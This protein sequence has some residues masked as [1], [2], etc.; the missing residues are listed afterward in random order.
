MHCTEHRAVQCPTSNITGNVTFATGNAPSGVVIGTVANFT[1]LPSYVWYGEVSGSTVRSGTCSAVNGNG[2][3]VLPKK[4]IRALSHWCLY[5][6]V[7]YTFTNT[8]LVDKK[9]LR[10]KLIFGQHPKGFDLWF[11]FMLYMDHS[12]VKHDHRRTVDQ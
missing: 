1:C 12:Y 9:T 3:W 2:T 4:C 6:N 7:L 8:A 10:I 11:S 5:I